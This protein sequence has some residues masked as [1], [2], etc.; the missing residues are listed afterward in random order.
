MATK[1]KLTKK[2]PASRIT[3]GADFKFPKKISV[4]A[5]DI[6][7]GRQNDPCRCALALAVKRTLGPNV[8]SINVSSSNIGGEL[9]MIKTK[10]YGEEFF[11]TPYLFLDLESEADDFIQSFDN[12]KK[13]VNPRSFQVMGSSV[14]LEGLN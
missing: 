5:D 1:K 6:K 3:V 12:D 8:A 4:T 10:F 9:K 13:S 2:K 14:D 7:N 11:I